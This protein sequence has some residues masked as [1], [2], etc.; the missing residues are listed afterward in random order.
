MAKKSNNDKTVTG[1]NKPDTTLFSEQDMEG[2]VHQQA[3]ASLGA[4]EEKEANTKKKPAK[5]A[6]KK[7]SKTVSKNLRQDPKNIPLELIDVDTEA[8]STHV[9]SGTGS[10]SSQD[11][12][13]AAII[14]KE[15]DG[16]MA[17]EH[18]ITP[19]EEPGIDKPSTEEALHEIENPVAVSLEAPMQKVQENVSNDAADQ[20]IAFDP[21]KPIYLEIHR[22]NIYHYFSRAI[23]LPSRYYP[24]R[25]FSDLQSVYTDQLILSNNAS[26]PDPEMVLLQ[27]QLKSFQLPGL[28]VQGRFAFMD[29][30][31]AI[32]SVKSV[33]VRSNAVKA[34]ILSDATLFD[35]GFIPQQ[36]IAV[37]TLEISTADFNSLKLQKQGTDYSAK[38]NKFNRTLG[39]LA[40][41]RNYS[42]LTSSGTGLYKSVSDHFFLAMQALEPAFGSAIL[43]NPSLSEFYSF[44][45]EE[46][47]P[48]EKPL[49]K[50]L[51]SRLKILMTGT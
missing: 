4:E 44:L 16:E 47:C 42:Y 37:G 30:P 48:G 1:E 28:N 18:T 9:T 45:F 3:A 14:E 27:V 35:G 17:A 21:A 41:I 15:M 24:N 43:S 31:L 49:L 50:W 11:A 23:V 8:S 39:L 6:A 26:N 5:T 12:M 20:H 29:F 33:I 7:A 36:L 10:E 13:A 2:L 38:I 22:G 40:F 32:T 25:A 19:Q 46:N 51:F 34:T